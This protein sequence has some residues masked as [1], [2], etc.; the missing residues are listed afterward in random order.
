VG[1]SFSPTSGVTPRLCEEELA[2]LAQLQEDSEIFD[3]FFQ[4]REVSGNKS[5]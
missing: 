4:N 5:Q 2:E 3:F 1:F